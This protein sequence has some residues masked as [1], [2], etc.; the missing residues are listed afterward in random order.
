[1]CKL[2]M[3]IDEITLILLEQIQFAQAP[4]LGGLEPHVKNIWGKRETAVTDW[5]QSEWRQYHDGFPSRLGSYDSVILW[6]SCMASIRQ[7]ICPSVLWNWA[8]F[9]LDSEISLHASG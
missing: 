3:I 2:E 4:D 9:V 8:L 5:K 1:M 6:D 7:A